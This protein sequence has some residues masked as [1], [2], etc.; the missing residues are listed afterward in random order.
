MARLLLCLFLALEL[1]LGVLLSQYSLVVRSPAV[2]LF[3]GTLSYTATEFRSYKTPRP[4]SDL[5][6]IVLPFVAALVY[7]GYVGSTFG[8]Q[9]WQMLLGVIL[10]GVWFL[11]CAVWVKVCH[12][13]I[14]SSREERRKE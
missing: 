5:W 7:G 12:E 10:G 13:E 8:D 6:L 14:T 3:L 4:M 2:V 11:V 1:V 9:G